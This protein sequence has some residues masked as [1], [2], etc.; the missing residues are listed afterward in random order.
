MPAIHWSEPQLLVEASLGWCTVSP[1]SPGVPE[2]V[3]VGGASI[4]DHGDTTINFEI[5]GRTPHLYYTRFNHCCLDRDLVR[6][7]L[8]FTRLD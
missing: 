8:T 6:V 1:Q 2:P 7:P 3:N 4:V 5:A